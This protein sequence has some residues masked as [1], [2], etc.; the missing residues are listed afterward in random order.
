MRFRD[1]VTVVTGSASGFGRAIAARLAEEG[2]SVVIADLDEAG[3]HETAALVAGAGAAAEVVVGDI[4]TPEGASAL[5]E[6][7][8]ARLGGIDVLVNNA[9]IAQLDT[10]GSWDCT[11]EVWDRLIRVDLTSV[12]LCSKRAIP[13]MR[14]RGRG[15]IVNIASI[16][17]SVSIG[18]AAYAAAKGGIVS[19]TR[20]AAAELAP[21]GIRM[22]CV[23]PGFMRTPM[24]TGERHGL[25]PE[26]QEARLAAMGA[27][28]PMGRTGTALDIAEAVL[29]LAGDEAAYVTG[30]ELVVDGGYVVR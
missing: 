17:A 20:H 24:A 9:G 27:R 29:Y 26:Q 6:R 16:A 7:T 8:V 2:A 30:Q 23:S 25:T 11:E 13:V 5:V 21:L 22:N 18:G 4:A 19:Y 10:T 28:V 1:R 14:E 15:A 3:A 12:F